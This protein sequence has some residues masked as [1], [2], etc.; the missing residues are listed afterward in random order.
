LPTED[1]VTAAIIHG[2][3][4]YQ[5]VYEK[6]AADPFGT[7]DLNETQHVTTGEEASLII[8]RIAGF[9]EDRVQSGGGLVFRDVTV[10][11]DDPGADPRTAVV[12]YC[13]DRGGLRLIEVDTGKLVPASGTFR[14]ES[15]LELLPDGSWRVAKIRNESVKC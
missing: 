10:A 6:F 1:P 11:V 12:S 7:R 13:V 2:W 5:R 8:E 15:T 14:E 9:R 3:Q 4:E